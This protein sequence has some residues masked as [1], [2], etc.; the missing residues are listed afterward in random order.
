MGLCQLSHLGLPLPPVPHPGG[1]DRPCSEAESKLWWGLPS[2]QKCHI[3]PFL[4]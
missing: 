3:P 1:Y 4:P 2:A